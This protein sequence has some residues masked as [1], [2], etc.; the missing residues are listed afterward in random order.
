MRITIASRKSDLAR[1]QAHSVGEALK[2]VHSNLEIIYQFRESLGDQNLNDPL[3]QMPEK[4]VFTQ[5]FFED[6]VQGRVDLVVHSWKDL[7]VE[8]RPETVIAATLPRADQRDLLLLRKDR[9]EQVQGSGEVRVLSSSPRRAYNLDG[10]LKEALPTKISKVIFENVRGNV[11][12]RVQKLLTSNNTD[13]LIMAKAA[14][15]RLL[16]GHGEEFLQMQKN[17]C[18][19]LEKCLVM[20]TPLERNPTAAAQGALAIEVK[21]SRKDILKLLEGINCEKTFNAVVEERK[22][23]KEYGGGCHQKV[24]V[25][26]R[27]REYGEIIYTRALTD[28]GQQIDKTEFFSSQ[29]TFLKTTLDKI[30][31]E[32]P[33]KAKWF[34][35]K[36]FDSKVPGGP[37]WIAKDEALPKNTEIA[38]GERVVWVSGFETWKKLAQRGVWVSG[39]N[40]SLGEGEENQLGA[41]YGS[42]RWTKL[43][44]SKACSSEGLKNLSTYDLIPLKTAPDIRG[45]TH[46]YW[47]SGSSFLR[48]LELYPWLKEMNHSC[49][50]GNTFEVISQQVPVTVFPS[51]D[52]WKE[53]VV[54]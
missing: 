12:T 49:G 1:I 22:R 30:F 39:C 31:P 18:E 36:F 3:W 47:M 41:I 19:A 48:A 34:E 13:G 51:Y 9:W 14:L 21:V 5:D 43:T 42:L 20:I 38:V 6:L 16:G 33:A 26:V 45:K 17:L 52:H 8:D 4:G 7:P 53:K 27:T 29:K 11:P 37:L 24:G 44:H 46:F 2:K 15:D 10:F 25:S 50:P 32:D 28:R 40:E 54:Q 23:L 35:R